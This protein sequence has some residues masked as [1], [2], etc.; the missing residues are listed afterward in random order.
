MIDNS[1]RYD[2]MVLSV[3]ALL[4]PFHRESAV[5]DLAAV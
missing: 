2:Q 1:S 3:L 5:K 4:I